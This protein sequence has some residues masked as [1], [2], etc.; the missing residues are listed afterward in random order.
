M[1]FPE[2]PPPAVSAAYAL[3]EVVWTYLGTAGGFS[4]SRIW[5]GVTPDGRAFCLKAYPAGRMDREVL[6]STVHR[7]MREVRLP[8]VPTVEATPQGRTAIE[9]LGRVWDLSTWMPG[10]ADFHT[11]PS[12]PRLAFAVTALAE[13]HRAWSANP[14]KGNHTRPAP[15]V[16]RRLSALSDWLWLTD[17]GWRPPFSSFD[18]SVREPAETAWRIVPA[19]ARRAIRELDPWRSI[20][21]TTHPCLCDV[22]LDHVLFD[23]DRVSGFIDFSAVK[24]D[25]PAVDLAR[26]LGSLV[27]D[28]PVRTAVALDA[29]QRVN[30]L[31][32]P[33]L[34]A[35]LDRTGTVVAAIHWLRSVYLDRRPVPNMDAVARRLTAVVERLVRWE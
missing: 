23:G 4:G 21:V 1:I 16:V 3:P 26:L 13:L 33:Q 9:H 29:Y 2:S 18:G 7:W 14:V 12:D 32:H 6:E 8:F 19:L 25:H 10:L 5:R 17:S 20:P 30:A 11:S 35:V 22:W 27:P 34:V 28:D 15:A 24:V 31:S